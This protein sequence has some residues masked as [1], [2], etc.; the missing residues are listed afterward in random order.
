M[1]YLSYLFRAVR[2]L[3]RGIENIIVYIKLKI[4]LFINNVGHKKV[5][6]NGLPY[7]SVNIGGCCT[8]GD[9]FA[10]NNGLRFN[11]I[12]F[13]QPCCIVVTKGACLKIGNDVGISQ[14]SIICH[15]SITIGNNVKIGGGAKIY[16]TNFHSLDP[17]LRR[18][19]NQD[20][21][22]KK[23]APV[24]IEHDAFIGA[25]VIVLAGVTIGANSIIGAG[26]VVTKSVPPNQVWGGNPACFLKNL[27]YE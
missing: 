12:G 4:S 18:E 2:Y 27:S 3:Y 24:V 16:D 13:P 1:I 25:G 11:P 7:I 20:M 6:S 8:F 21:L 15:H 9:N 17:I 26:S 19:R 14:A 23:C 10:M 22:H 5:I